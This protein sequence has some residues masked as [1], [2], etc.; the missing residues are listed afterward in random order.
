MISCG[1]NG[2]ADFDETV[3]ESICFEKAPL[4]LFLLLNVLCFLQVRQ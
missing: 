1:N 3:A 2:N 4:N